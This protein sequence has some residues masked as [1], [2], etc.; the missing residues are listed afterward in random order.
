MAIFPNAELVVAVLTNSDLT[1]LPTYVKLQVADEILGLRKSH[2]WL[3]LDA[4]AV[5]AALYNVM[6]DMSKGNFPKRVPNKPPAH[7]LDEY[8][9]EYSHPGFGTVA[10]RLEEDELHVSYEAFKGVLTHYHFESFTTVLR[11]VPVLSMGEL[12]TFQTGADGRVSGLSIESMD[13][14]AHFAKREVKYSQATQLSPEYHAR[15]SQT[16]MMARRQQ[17]LGPLHALMH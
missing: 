16:V 8:A 17:P 5:T 15:H 6:D 14:Q 9:G 12:L 3:T 1:A 2:D 10:V 4:I 7:D 13:P 11:H